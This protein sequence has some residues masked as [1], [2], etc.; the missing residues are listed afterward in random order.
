M[1]TKKEKDMLSE[2][3][4]T[5]LSQIAQGN[6]KMGEGKHPILIASTS[7]VMPYS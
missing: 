6:F 5:E 3:L 4:M 7:N 1:L 2:H